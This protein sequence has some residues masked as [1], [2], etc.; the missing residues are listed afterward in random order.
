[1]S[2]SNRNIQNQSQYEELNIHM[3]EVPSPGLPESVGLD[4]VLDDDIKTVAFNI[5]V[6]SI[7]LN[8]GQ[9]SV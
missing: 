6:Y 1:M 5:K 2:A 4:H 7:C 9:R 8:T 3:N